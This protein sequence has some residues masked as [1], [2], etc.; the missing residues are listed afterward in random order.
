MNANAS[1]PTRVH[2]T[3][4]GPRDGLQNE[5]RPVPT[6][7]KVAFVRA[8]VAAGHTDIEVSSFV[9]PDVVPQLADAKAVF[10]ALGPSPDGVRYMA[11]APNM[12]GFERAREVGVDAIAVFTAAS[13]R[14]NRR[15]TNASI[16][17]SLRRFEP[18]VHAAKNEGMDVRGYVS[19]AI[20][21]PFEGWT[22]PSAVRDVATS[23]LELG[24]DELSIGD[25]IGAGTPGHVRRLLDVLLASIAVDKIVMHFHDTRG[26]AVANVVE[27]LAHGIA[28][29]DAS[30]GGLGGCP[31]APG[32]SGNLATEDV[33]FLL[34]GLGISHDVDMDAQRIAA[35]E[36]ASHVGHALPSRVW[37]APKLP[38]SRTVTGNRPKDS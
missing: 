32:S 38:A 3:E 13:E 10:D 14:F 28:R 15:N 1:M 12:K 16:A 36:V 29:F 7:A 8:L 34:D 17:E 31:F 21:C 33:L 20:A 37:Q 19:T 11:L 4:V 9:R 2:L 25:T 30:A 35:R 23:L 27:A 5:Q 24:C 22:S 6:D 26:M 18:V